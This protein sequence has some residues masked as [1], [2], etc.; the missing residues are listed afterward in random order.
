[1]MVEPLIMCKELTKTFGKIRA[2][3]RINFSAPPGLIILLGKNGSG[4]ST[5]AKIISTLLPYDEGNVKVKGKEINSNK[6]EIRQMISYL[7]QDNIVEDALTVQEIVELYSRLFREPDTKAN[8]L[9]DNLGLSPYRDTLV[10]NL[11][12][13][14]KRRLSILLAFLPDR[15]I[16]IL[17][18]PFEEL[19]FWGRIKVTELIHHALKKGKSIF[20][21]SHTATWLEEIADYILILHQGKLLYADSPNNL[22]QA[23][24][25]VYAIEMG[26]L[27]EIKKILKNHHNVTVAINER[28]SVVGERHAL[29]NITK[30]KNEEIREASISEICAFIVNNAALQQSNFIK[31]L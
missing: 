20:L 2:L 8:E 25:D 3:D 29:S 1:M 9:L 11:S 7:S 19:D 22:K 14:L 10:G 24:K 30:I 13:G 21:I 16:Y 4:K 28:V 5:L 12:G 6:R 18:E 31:K 15:D 23:F 27:S 26:S 17:D